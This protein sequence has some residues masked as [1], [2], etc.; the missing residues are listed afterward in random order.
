M[1][2]VGLVLLAVVAIAIQTE[3]V[4]NY[5]IHR[6]TT[7]L[8]EELNA[9][10]DV[11]HV[12]IDFLN[13]MV[14]DGL[15][16]E[17]QQ[18]DTLLYGGQIRAD[19]AAGVFSLFRS[20][21]ALEGVVLRDAE[22]NIRRAGGEPY[23]NA[24]FILDYLSGGPPDSVYTRPK[25]FFLQAEYLSLENV[26]FVQEDLVT[27]NRLR[28]RLPEGYIAFEEID[29]PNN[30][31]DIGVMTLAHPD[32]YI[33]KFLADDTPV[34]TDTN[35]VVY[36]YPEVPDSLR[37][38]LRIGIAHLSIPDGRLHFYNDR[39]TG[40]RTLYPNS[41]D[42]RHVDVDRI[43]LGADNVV[44]NGS[45]VTAEIK[46][47]SAHEQRSDF[48][49]NQLRADFVLTPRQMAF[50]NLDMRTP[51][52]ELGDTMVMKF[53]D[54]TA[55]R[56]YNNEVIMQAQFNNSR[57]AVRDIMAFAPALE[58][59][60]IFA[61]NRNEDIYIDGE[62]RGKVNSL[63]A[64]DMK[65][66]LADGTVAEG[67]FRS[68]NLAVK[69]EEFL[70]F[71]L[72]RLRTSM[73]SVAAL[74]PDFNPPESYYKVTYLDFS[75][76]YTGFFSDFVA[77]GT[78]RTNLG[79]VETDIRLNL[80]EGRDNA[81]YSGNLALIDFDL[82]EWNRNPDWG[83][84]TFRSKVEN[85]RGLRF[86]ELSA[87]L[88]AQVES[89]TYKGYTYRD[90]D[91]DGT[92]TQ[93]KFDGV[94]ISDDD[95]AHFN[96]E[97]QIDLNEALPKFDFIASIDTLSLGK[98]NLVAR[99]LAVSG[100]LR[101]NFVGNNIS[102]IQGD[103]AVSDFYL[104]TDDRTFNVDTLLLNSEIFATGN[105][106]LEIQSEVVDGKLRGTF[107]VAQVP[108]VL[109]GFVER[110]YPAFAERFKIKA[111][112]QPS[113]RERSFSFEVNIKDS[114]NLTYFIDERLDTLRRVRAIGY[115][116]SN[117]DSIDF[118][119]NLP[120]LRYDDLEIDDIVLVG[121]ATGARS[122]ISGGVGA[123]RMGDR[124]E[125]P[126][127]YVNTAL[128][129]DTVSFNVNAEQ[130][131]S[132]VKNFNLNGEFFL[133]ED[134]RFQVTFDSSNLKLY[135]DSWD[136]ATDNFI[137]FGNQTVET[138]NFRLSND[139]KLIAL[140]SFGERGLRL[141]MENIALSIIDDLWVYEPLDFDGN[142][143]LIAET[144]D[145]FKLSDFKVDAAADTFYINGDPYGKLTV[146]AEADNLQSQI[147]GSVRIQDGA[148]LLLAEGYYNPKGIRSSGSGD[149]RPNYFDFTLK[150]Y[151]F[152][153]AFSRYFIG[154]FTS[155]QQ[156]FFDADIR[157]YG[158]PGQPDAPHSRG[159]VRI[160]DAA[161]TIDYLQ[162]RYFIK[163]EV[164]TV[165]DSYFD[166]S[167][168]KLY[169]IYGNIAT[170]T[171]GGITHDHLR[172]LGLDVIIQ[173]P[174]FLMLNTEKEDNDLFYG[175]AIGEAYVEFTGSFKQ[176]NLYIRATSQENTRVVIPIG[177]AQDGSEI[178][179]VTFIDR[180]T[181]GQYVP[182]ETAAE[183]TGLSIEMDLTVTPDAE[184]LM[185][186]DEQAGDII[187]GRGEADLQI[188]VS[189][190]ADFE[191]YGDY[192]ITEGEYLFTYINLVNKPF[193]VKP[194]GSISWT[195][196]PY[197]AVLDLEAFYQNLS[198]RPYNFILEYLN[199]EDER[200]A[201]NDP[202]FVDLTM[203][204]QGSLLQP[205]IDFD[206]SF[207]NL[208]G[209]L[210]NY[211]DSKLQIVERDRNE[212]NRQVFGLILLGDFLPSNAALASI[213]LEQT[214]INT[215]SE[216]LSNQLSIYVT[217]LIS[218]YISEDG[219]LT[220]I[221]LDINYREYR[222][223]EFDV[224]DPD[225]NNFVGR[226]VTVRPN[227][228]F[229]DNR[230]TVQ[231]GLNVDLDGDY[232]NSNGQALNIDDLML[233]YRITRDN[234]F[235]VRIF[236]R[237]ELNIGGRRYRWGGGISYRREFDNFLKNLEED[238]KE[239]AR[240]Q[241]EGGSGQGG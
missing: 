25:P 71:E 132:T 64:Y 60:R 11:E 195:G 107:D 152:P 74:L 69:G 86:E 110:N 229:F 126:P 79:R 9:E 207:P 19:F 186:F 21:L 18:G 6:T 52:S 101:F 212:L 89:L 163:D 131:L 155:D 32:V 47:L 112:R 202:T 218:Q 147:T 176:P 201:A 42:F 228:K 49:L 103:A 143:F 141:S 140:N 175:R 190:T 75:G 48:L 98:L 83:R 15:Y 164:V 37:R 122:N 97:G 59:N 31:I 90:L 56:D 188:R 100:D 199:T 194:G 105:R 114:K 139:D 224:N 28:A 219:A 17:D 189:R 169:D 233:E 81:R 162:T 203:Q 111:P 113:E 95:N 13:G 130:F 46:E 142:L 22:I 12:S 45:E 235:K 108:N 151:A 196:S 226:E 102:N 62:L 238:A 87:T 119:I 161:I 127:V 118:E 153:V 138:N 225:L 82:G 72:E 106:V 67:N 200:S 80:K 170:V 227:L 177:G 185:L 85:G 61:N 84:V 220:D 166:A 160:Y 65:L 211:T 39:P 78:L 63:R 234:R 35:R 66:R 76:R 53:R 41:I 73:R 193:A 178:S 54:F 156:G 208:N 44:I 36:D 109:L 2:A 38:P 231:G 146:A 129:G 117:T 50:Y 29:L 157:F 23:H 158:E 14:L 240:R 135:N 115:Y 165:N 179:F 10:V 241:R 197:E 230:L 33:E 181:I 125:A 124:L 150:T 26:R 68:R 206:I 1:T 221:D 215:I 209:R 180:D 93:R 174:Q 4:Q 145:L 205:S 94:F 116:D 34:P 237:S 30:H 239:Y 167:G 92:F 223:G 136:I 5:L 27:G 217:S 198:V 121:D 182:T 236:Q 173:S 58:A 70:D 57:V 144:D 213:D 123:F 148:Q 88:D 8:S 187:R 149:F 137:R 214:S 192:V 7:Y 183:A 154:A 24:Q 222:T 133:V 172:N 99:P 43:H 210:R 134:G 171:Q 91:V 168:G 51:Y 232:S 3:A 96:F 128:R 159:Q 191:M 120:R 16:I 20:R 77:D 184:V 55:F 204:M 40:P 216:M 104:T